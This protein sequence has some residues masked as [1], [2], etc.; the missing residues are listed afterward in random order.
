MVARDGND[1]WSARFVANCKDATTLRHLCRNAMI[2][3]V[4]E[5]SCRSGFLCRSATTGQAHEAQAQYY[6]FYVLS[7]F[8]HF[9]SKYNLNLQGLGAGC[10][11]HERKQVCSLSSGELVYSINSP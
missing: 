9:K 4:L 8:F 6:R 7:E 3:K 10:S 11:G 1:K 5:Y 2:D